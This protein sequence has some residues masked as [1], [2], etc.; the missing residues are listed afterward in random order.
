MTRT[1]PGEKLI[2]SNKKA[3]HDYSILE[4]LEAGMVLLGTEVKAARE[5]RVNLKD[6]YAMVKQGEAFLLNCHISPY[7]HGNRENHDPTRTRKLLLHSNEI[8]KLAGKTQ[9]KGLTLVPLR[10]YL[11]RG[12]IKIELGVARGKKL[13]DKR[14]TERRKELDREARVQLKKRQ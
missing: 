2:A 1:E 8:R 9:E 6:S 12:K 11:K 14:E 5:G 7:S 10:V 13:I 3:Y 4:K